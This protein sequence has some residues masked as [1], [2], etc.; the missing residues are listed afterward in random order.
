MDSI[1]KHHTKLWGTH[2]THF[3]A[4]SPFELWNLQKLA[5]NRIE[6]RSLGF[7]IVAGFNPSGNWS[8][9]RLWLWLWHTRIRK[10]NRQANHKFYVV[11]RSTSVLSG[12]PCK[13]LLSG[14]RQ[15]NI[16]GWKTP[17]ITRR[18][19]YIYSLS[20]FHRYAGWRECNTSCTLETTLALANKDFVHLQ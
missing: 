4:V 7:Q 17:R 9:H 18:R 14:K 2:W 8:K 11:W 19:I 15:E 10:S 5:S 1:F 12:C 20:T 6:N 13:D 16:A 3:F